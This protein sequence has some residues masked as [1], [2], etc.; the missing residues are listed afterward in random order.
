MLRYILKR[1]IWMIPIILGVAVLVFTIMYFCPGDPAT[2]ILG[3]GATQAE[4]DAL[5][6]TMG[7]NRGYFV[8]LFEFLTDTFIHFDLGNSYISKGSILLEITQR[9]PRT[10]ILATMCMVI[11]IVVGVPLGI[12]AAVKQD[13]IG[14]RVSMILALVGVSIPNFWLA[15][16]L[17]LLFSVKLNWL[18]AMGIGSFKHYILPT[19]ACCMGGIATQARQS[20]SSMLEVIRSDYITTARSKGVSN[21]GVIF[22]HEL[23]NALIPVITVAGNQFSM[24]LGG[25]LII[26]Q[27]FSIPGMGSFLITAVFNRDYPVIQIGAVFMAIVF[28]IIMLLVDLLFA[29]VD[30]RIKSQYQGKPLFRRKGGKENKHA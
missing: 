19:L 7:L 3:Q 26:E 2:I 13:S 30:P 18:P 17:V 23:T 10:V 9:L 29:F 27:I 28:S 15:L 20:R 11:G 24:L 8:R 14:D 6:E 1:I 22:K 4:I 21:L 16:L 5:R 12:L 25:T